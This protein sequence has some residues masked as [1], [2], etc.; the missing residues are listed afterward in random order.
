M[1]T[2]LR[3]AKQHTLYQTQY[4]VRKAHID[5]VAAIL[6]LGKTTLGEGYLTTHGLY[7]DIA[8]NIVYVATYQGEPIGYCVAECLS[9]GELKTQLL[10]HPEDP[11]PDL[12]QADQLGRLGLL[13]AAGVNPCFRRNGIA[14]SMLK[15]SIDDLIQRGV[16]AI[17]GLAWKTETVHVGGVLDRLGFKPRQEYPHL[18]DMESIEKNYHCPVCGVPPCQCNGVLYSWNRSLDQG[19]LHYA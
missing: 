12:I 4:S 15:D 7:R 5:D 19:L 3:S 18:W 13:Q 16:E 17:I 10:G 11:F 9:P 2:T 14:T 1:I 8:D 6:Y